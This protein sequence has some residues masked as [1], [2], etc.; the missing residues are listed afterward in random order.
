M[1]DQVEDMIDDVV[2]DNTAEVESEARQMGWVP[3]G[4]FRGD[5]SKW[6]S[7]DEFVERGREILPIVL[8][9]KEEL[10][11]KNK[12]LENELRELKV[13]VDEFKE[14]RKSDKERMYKQ[15]IADL[16][17]KKKEAIEDGNGGLAVELDDAIDEIKVAQ[18]ELQQAPTKKEPEANPP[19][20]EFVEWVQS[21]DWYAKNAMLQHAA[22]AAGIE[23]G[24]EFPG[25]QGKKFLDKVTERVKERYPE[26]FGNPRRESAGQVEGGNTTQSRTTK[27]QSYNNLPQEARDACDRF[28]KQGIMSQE[29]YVKGY[30]WN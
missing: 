29:E 18:Q 16:K 10:L 20:P 7:A 17:D 4:E 15:A 27:K 22:N 19:A 12:A 3:E 23:I 2:E 11:H 24:Q 30:E 14:Y 5:K 13:A 26:K 21:N 6:R 28:V 9:N 25:L 8:K 1:E